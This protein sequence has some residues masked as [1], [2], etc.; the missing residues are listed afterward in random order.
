MNIYALFPLIAA[1]AYIPLIVNTLITRP[2]LKQ[3]KLYIAFLIPAMLWSL[4]DYFWRGHFFPGDSLFI[5]KLVL[6]I[7]SLAL[8]QF[9]FFTSSFYGEKFN[10]SSCNFGFSFF[11]V[12]NLGYIA[13]NFN[14]ETPQRTS[15]NSL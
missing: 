13:Y 2:L 10:G 8:V 1:I 6:I 9:H 3:H 11:P 14:Q 5:S 7:L 4:A 15:E 12:W